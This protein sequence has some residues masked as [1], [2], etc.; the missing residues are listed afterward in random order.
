MLL[1]FG[2][3]PFTTYAKTS[4]ILNEGQPTIF[5]LPTNHAWPESKDL[6]AISPRMRAK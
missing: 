2:P 5:A 6:A 1:V 3:I 4:V